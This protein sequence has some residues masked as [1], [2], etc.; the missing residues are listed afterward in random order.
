MWNRLREAGSCWFSSFRSI[1]ALPRPRPSIFAS[2]R[3]RCLG[4]I[5]RVYCSGPSGEAIG[6]ATGNSAVSKTSGQQGVSTAFP[7][8]DQVDGPRN[9]WWGPPAEGALREEEREGEHPVPPGREEDH[10]AGSRL[11]RRA[12]NRYYRKHRVRANRAA[13]P[14]DPAAECLL[15]VMSSA[16]FT[17][18]FP[19]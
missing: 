3:G 15:D 4:T 10:R 14:A 12:A 17:R 13:G 5:G 18:P 8:P 11:A 1:P 2:P 16:S 19:R 6:G 9:R 7:Q